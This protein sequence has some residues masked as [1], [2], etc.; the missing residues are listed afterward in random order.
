MT[1][2]VKRELTLLEPHLHSD[3]IVLLH[4]TM[5][6][7][8]HSEYKFQNKELPY[9]YLPRGEWARATWITA[10]TI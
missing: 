4:D 1:T 3:S 7:Q 8:L 5:M 2:K 10:I 6:L 9:G